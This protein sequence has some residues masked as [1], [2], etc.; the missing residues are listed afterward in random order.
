M[1]NVSTNSATH[2]GLLTGFMRSL[3]LQPWRPALETRNRTLTYQQLADVAWAFGRTALAAPAPFDSSPVV[4]VLSSRCLDAYAGV[5]G[6]LMAGKGFVP[7]NPSFPVSRTVAMLEASGARM[8][9]VGSDGVRVLAAILS[10]CR[11][12][13]LV[14]HFKDAN[15]QPD[16]SERI[17]H[18]FVACTPDKGAS[19]DKSSILCSVDP[20]GIAYLMFTSGSTGAPKGIPVSHGNVAAYLAAMH[21][22]YPLDA[23]DKCSQAF[24]LTFDLSVHDL[25]VT[26]GTGACL[27]VVPKERVMAPVSFIRQSRITSWFSV[28]TVV[29]FARRLGTLRPD[30]LP[31]LKYSLF[32]GEVLTISAASVWQEAAPNSVV[33]NLYGPTETTIASTCYRWNPQL[34]SHEPAERAVSIGKPLDGL[35]VQLVDADLNPVRRGEIGE[36]C[37]SGPQVTNGYLNDAPR[38]AA[39]FISL[40]GSDDRKWYRTGDLAAISADGNLDFHGRVD[41]QIKIRGFRVELEEVD[42][43]LRRAAK[44]DLAIVVAWPLERSRAEALYAIVCDG[45]STC[46]RAIVATCAAELPPYMVPKRVFFID[47]MPIGGSGKIDRQALARFVSDRLACESSMGQ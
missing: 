21:A 47:S 39:S 19:A 8:L 22:R 5:L 6:T 42:R 31:S 40:F 46:D 10:M 27:C 11:Q 45:A 23:T 38:T 1:P 18:R 29:A 37:I 41:N 24:E 13:M 32:C 20:T 25:F 35:S 44:T 15:V 30:S 7:L 14:L 34:T 16:R 43:L 12:S 17:N 9:I 4:A 2:P 26:W 3:N 28:P 33:D 36:L